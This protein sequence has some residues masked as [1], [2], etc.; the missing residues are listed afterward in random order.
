MNNITP[1][2]Y[3]KNLLGVSTIWIVCLMIFIIGQGYKG[4]YLP[5]CAVTIFI[6]PL[7]I[8]QH[9]LMLFVLC[10]QSFKLSILTGFFSGIFLALAVRIVLALNYLLWSS[11]RNTEAL[12]NI[13]GDYGQIYLWMGLLG[14]VCMLIDPFFRVVLHKDLFR[15]RKPSVFW[16]R[17][18][19]TTLFYRFVLRKDLSKRNNKDLDSKNQ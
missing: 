19:P 2:A 3:L 1:R 15:S 5:I 4:E 11:D 7:A 10:E 9:C 13:F 6:V 12:F 8:I 16:M 18:S 14:I 17:Y